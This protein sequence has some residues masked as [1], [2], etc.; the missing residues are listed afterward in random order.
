MMLSG[1]GARVWY[2]IRMLS[3]NARI[4]LIVVAALI[5]LLLI[6]AWLWRRFYRDDHTDTART[7][8]K[9]SLLPI[10]AI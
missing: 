2:H 6:A 1:A 10:G 5:P 9:N 7:V 4:F 3:A 8:A